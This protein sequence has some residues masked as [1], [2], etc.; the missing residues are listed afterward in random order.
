MA[1]NLAALPAAKNPFEAWATYLDMIAAK[2]KAIVTGGGTAGVPVITPSTNT[3]DFSGF[4]M[5]TT[6]PGQSGSAAQFG[7]STPWAQAAAQNIVVQIDGKAVATAVQNQNNSGN[8]TGFS[9][10]GDFKTL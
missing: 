9:R 5:P 7:A 2:A 8:F 6:T 10:L 1:R 4:A 3:T